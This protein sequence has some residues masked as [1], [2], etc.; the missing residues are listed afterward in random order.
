MRSSKKPW[1]SVILLLDLNKLSLGLEI[2]LCES[3][4]LQLSLH[5]AGPLPN[6]GLKVPA[7]MKTRVHDF[8]FHLAFPNPNDSGS[9]P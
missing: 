5:P 2:Q 1:T 7:V 3:F 9:H 6:L 4:M 8:S